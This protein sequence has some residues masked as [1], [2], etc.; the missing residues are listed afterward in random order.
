MALLTDLLNLDLSGSTEKI[1]AE[2][3]WYAPLPAF[4]AP[5]PS[6]SSVTGYAPRPFLRR[7]GVLAAGVGSAWPWV[8]REE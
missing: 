3:I 4:T 8:H 2:Y 5:P 6:R 7:R 1:I